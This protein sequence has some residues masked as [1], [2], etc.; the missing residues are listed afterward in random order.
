MMTINTV[1][2]NDEGRIVH[3]VGPFFALREKWGIVICVNVGT[4]AKT[5]YMVNKEIKAIEEIDSLSGLLKDR[6]RLHRF[7]GR[8]GVTLSN[9]W[10]DRFEKAR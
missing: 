2:P 10:L 7:L 8:F 1:R 3:E 4:Y 9:E 6:K 5:L